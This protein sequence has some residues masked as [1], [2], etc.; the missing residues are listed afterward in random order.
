MPHYA[1]HHSTLLSPTQ[2]SALATTI[3]NL[4][5]TLFSAASIFVNVTFHATTLQTQTTFVGGQ[6]VQTNYIN[7]FLRPRGPS[8]APKLATLIQEISK[9]W[10][11]IVVTPSSS[12]TSSISPS[13]LPAPEP[14]TINLQR[15]QSKSTFY[16]ATIFPHS[17]PVPDHRSTAIASKPTEQGRLDNPLT[18]HNI[19]LHE[20]IAAGAEQGFLLPLAGQD[21]T[22]MQ[23][24][25]AEFERRAE[26]G[27][28]SIRVLVGEIKVKS[29]L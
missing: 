6:Q 10:E 16:D 7:G 20:S 22:W 21:G 1:I 18:L 2:K 11:D 25:M 9:A 19:F 28:E 13:S 23:E 17:S 24:N 14:L 27:D 3:T 4:H 12:T 8:N 15:L 5:T 26:T 29:E